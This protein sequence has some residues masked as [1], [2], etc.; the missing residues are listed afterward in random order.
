MEAALVS[1]VAMEQE[2]LEATQARKRLTPSWWLE[3]KST[4]EVK[5]EVLCREEDSTGD[6]SVPN[7]Q[8]IRM[9][10]LEVEP[11]RVE[12]TLKMP[13]L[14]LGGD[15]WGLNEPGHLRNSEL[16]TL[17]VLG[18]LVRPQPS[19]VPRASNFWKRVSKLWQF[20]KK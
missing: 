3:Q 4:T 14:E 7:A 1:S 12:E 18:S 10:K 5:K 17:P 6:F 2:S 8:T 16:T 13:K 15:E 19:W 20:F 9:E 11:M